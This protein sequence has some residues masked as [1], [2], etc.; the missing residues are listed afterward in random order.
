[1]PFTSRRTAMAKAASFGAVPTSRVTA[2][3]A[4]WYTSGIH[5]WNGATPILK[6]SPA[7]RNTRPNT[8]KVRSLA[9]PA[10]RE[11]WVATS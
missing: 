2:V 4:P 9:L 8:K 1:M 3:G 6:A 11:A 7:T 5:M 10:R